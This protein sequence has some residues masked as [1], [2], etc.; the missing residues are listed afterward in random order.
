MDKSLY[1]IIKWITS[2][3]GEDILN[4]PQRLK[5]YVSNYANSIHKDDRI[6]FGRAIE[7]GFY[8]ELKRANKSNR[9]QVKSSMIL[10]LQNITGFDRVRCS[11]TIELLDAVITTDVPETKPQSNSLSPSIKAKSHISKRTLL[12][13][14]AAF[15][16]A[17]TGSFIYSVLDNK[18][19]NQTLSDG[20]WSGFAGLGIAIGLI[21]VQTIH[22]KKKFVFS[23]LIKYS[24]IGFVTGAVGWILGVLVLSVIFTNFIRIYIIICWGIF[25]LGLGL[26]VSFYVPNY[27]KIRAMLAGLVGGIFGGLISYFLPFSN[28]VGVW[29]GDAFVGFTIAMMIS[30]VEEAFREAW[31]TVVWNP[32]EMRTIALGKKPIL[33]GSSKDADIYLPNTTGVS[34]SSNIVASIKIENNKII[35]DDIQ[36]RKQLTI[37]NGDE[38]YIEKI[39]VIINSK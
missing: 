8:M 10:R 28:V 1:E 11:A 5:P 26:G 27:P 35:F 6:A 13:A 3:Q 37:K 33:F 31:I 15:A 38:V 23:S 16:G 32:N 2:E 22:L 24:L 21:I 30:L 39:K 7:Q 25:G 18:S 19:W 34:S 17:L 12:F 4:D 36:N 9:Q 29:L 20:V 14:I